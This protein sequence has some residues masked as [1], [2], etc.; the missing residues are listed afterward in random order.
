MKT[1]TKLLFFCISIILLAGCKQ[2][3][4]GSVE[5]IK[6][7]TAAIDDYR[8]INADDTPGDWLSY[9]R[10]YA[11]DRYSI[12]EKINKDNIKNLGLAWSLSIGTTLNGIE[13]TPVVVD[14]IMFF[15]GPWS[16]VYAVNAVTGQ[17]I[18]TYDPKVP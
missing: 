1:K 17:M 10:N 14:G 9:G 18:W 15:T 5:H 2:I 6:K 12:L 7:V 11:E 16:K 8:L 4:Q 13:T 3:E